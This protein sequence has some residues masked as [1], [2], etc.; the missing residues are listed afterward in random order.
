[1]VYRSGGGSMAIPSGSN[2]YYLDITLFGP[3]LGEIGI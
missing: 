2:R 1:M 3:G